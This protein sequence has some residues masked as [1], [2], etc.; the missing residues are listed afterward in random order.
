[1]TRD[2][3]ADG[4]IGVII[5]TYQS[6]AFITEC[7][8][9]LFAASG[10]GLRVVVID[11]N[12]ADTTCQVVRDWALG[13]VPYAHPAASPLATPQAMP[14]PLS[15]A[16]AT[17]IEPQTSAQQLTLLRSPVNGGFAF[18]IN[19]GLKLLCPDPEIDIFWVLNPDCVVPPETVPAILAAARECSFGL[20]GGRTIYYERPWEIQTDGGRV[21]RWNGVCHSVN[22]GQAADSVAMP[23][24]ATIDYVTG[25]NLIVSRKFVEQTG[26][27]TEDYFLYYEEVDWAFRRQN[28]SLQLCRD[29]RVFHRGGTSIGTGDT[30]RRP[31]PFAN[32]FNYRNRL[33]FVR[34]FSPSNYPVALMFAL[35]KAA[36]LLAR[37]A[38]DEAAAVFTGALSLAPPKGVRTRIADPAAQKIAFGDRK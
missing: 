2:D 8:E 34:R 18:A 23:D 20:L 26:P 28:L 35:A 14:K 38:W 25:A 36:S 11:N 15:F 31:S 6:G 30:T 19:L 10:S 13:A 9:S 33:R 1:M 12:S 3:A 37:L 7:L 27:M 32:Y 16:E 22:A 21:S 24:A 29:V 4:K 17:A 5:V